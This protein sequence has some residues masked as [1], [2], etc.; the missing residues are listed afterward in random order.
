VSAV[1]Q[2]SFAEEEEGDDNNGIAGS[3]TA[4]A[5]ALLVAVVVSETR[6]LRGIEPHNPTFTF[7]QLGNLNDDA[8]GVG[9]CVDFSVLVHVVACNIDDGDD[10]FDKETGDVADAAMIMADSV[11][12]CLFVPAVMN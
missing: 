11:R 3:I 1:L 5:L 2:F 7:T 6:D 10:E 8:G 9:A 12:L 4:F